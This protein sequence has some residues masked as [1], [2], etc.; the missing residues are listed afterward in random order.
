MVNKYSLVSGC[1]ANIYLSVLQ[2][3]TGQIKHSSNS[4]N[5]D[6]AYHPGELASVC[7]TP[8]NHAQREQLSGISVKNLSFNSLL[9]F[10]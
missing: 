10:A 8:S 6:M 7:K 2:H 9:Y 3:V 4:Q 1:R 5:P